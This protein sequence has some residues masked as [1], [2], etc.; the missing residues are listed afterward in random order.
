MDF[1]KEKTKQN[2][3]RETW[4]KFL[5]ITEIQDPLSR[6]SRSIGVPDGIPS[7][8]FLKKKRFNGILLYTGMPVFLAMW[9]SLLEKTLQRHYLLEK[10]E[11]SYTRDQTRNKARSNRTS[12]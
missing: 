11:N 4:A 12:K 5:L 9:P 1:F 7:L 2:K 3:E 10:D 8:M 6:S